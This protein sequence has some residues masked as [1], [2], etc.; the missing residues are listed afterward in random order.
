MSKILLFLQSYISFYPLTVFIGLL[1][2]GFNL[3]ISEDVLIISSAI[4]SK[5]DHSLLF[6]VLIALYFGAIISDYLIYLWGYLISR[7]FASNK[8]IGKLA[9]ENKMGRIS[10]KVRKNA[11]LTNLL[12]RFIP[13]GVRNAL[14]LYLGL[15]KF[16]FWKFAIYDAISAFVSIGTLFTLIFI[17]GKKGGIYIKIGGITLFVCLIAFAVWFIFFSKDKDESN[18]ELMN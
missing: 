12:C 7:G 15:S 17:M 16:K 1:L 13:F 4:L 8:H 2:A 14:F 9:D 11:F 5:T 18:Q 3:P 10:K 6:P